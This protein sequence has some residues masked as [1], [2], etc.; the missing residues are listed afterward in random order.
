L[1]ALSEHTDPAM[2]LESTMAPLIDDVLVAMHVAEKR[3][4]IASSNLE[5]HVNLE[6]RRKVVAWLVKAFHVVSFDDQLL[7]G[8]VQLA[9]SYLNNCRKFISGSILQ[10]IVMACVCTMLKLATAD[11]RVYSVPDLIEHIT[12]NQ[13]TLERVLRVE[14][15]VLA[16]VEF[17]LST[18]TIHQFLESFTL[19][20]TIDPSSGVARAE[21]DW[22]GLATVPVQEAV[23]GGPAVA[24]PK[25]F[26]LADFLCQLSLLNHE[27]LDHLPSL[28]AASAL[29]L[30]VWTLRGPSAVKAVLLEDIGTTW[31]TQSHQLALCVTALHK[32][33][34][35]PCDLEA[36][37]TVSEK[38][39][40]PERQ[41][42]SEIPAPAD[43]GLFLNALL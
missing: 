17:N 27:M 38:F 19:R 31:H 35:M 12:H 16:G 29:I 37:V 7:Y 15:E 40:A 8:T 14:R 30:S 24:R 13:I 25:F 21:R 23:V 4:R 42:V 33:W 6:H 9:D 18:P 1:S 28:L 22:I 11:H 39:A 34:V 41:E 10:S 36:S 32:E 20:I 43:V 3:L 5:Q 2:A 26:H